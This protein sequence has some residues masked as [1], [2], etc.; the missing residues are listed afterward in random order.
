MT[1]SIDFDGINRAALAAARSLLPSLIPGG[2]F[3]S[4]E[5]VVKNP[6]R[7]DRKAGSFSVNY[8]TGI[9]KDFA[10]ED[11]GGDVISLV[12]YRRNCSQGDAAR[13][14]ANKLGVPLLKANGASSATTTET[15]ANPRGHLNGHSNEAADVPSVYQGADAGPTLRPNEIRRHIYASDGVAMRVKIKKADGSFLNW[16]RVFVDGVPVGWQPKKPQ[17]NPMTIERYHTSAPRLIPST[18]N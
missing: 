8:K 16:Y 4:L 11:G 9:W 5:Y 7:D 6:C 3:R 14:L 10:N 1:S 12:A 15:T 2:T 17:R 18:R 13:E